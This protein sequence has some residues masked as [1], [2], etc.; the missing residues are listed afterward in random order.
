MKRVG[1]HVSSAG[2]VENSPLNAEKIQAKAFA[3][4]TKNQKQWNA[5]PLSSKN[6]DD[7][8]RNCED[9]GF[10]P[11]YILPH[12][13]YLINLGSPEKDGLIRSRDAFIDEIN[14]CS[15]LGLKYLNFHPGNHKKMISEDECLNLISESLNLALDVTKGVTLVIEN[16][17]GQGTSLGYR[18]EH[19]AH[20]IDKTEDKSRI[21]VCIDTCHT[22]ASGYD[23]RTF[24]TYSETMDKF[25]RIV[26]FKYLKGMHLNDSKVKLGSHVDRHH[27]LGQGELGLD[28]FKFIMSDP[29]ID[30]I[31]MILETIDSSIWEKEIELL[32]SYE[33]V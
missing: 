9:N 20:I 1:A 29:R 11:D 10:I 26:G 32:Y 24:E 27:S 16:T 31:P 22:F 2:G 23:L 7:F 3:L 4:F 12:D 18:F 21:G 5:K 17:A 13:S 8:Q 30:E 6:I 33:E 15:Q 14:R 28:P 25:E 19:L